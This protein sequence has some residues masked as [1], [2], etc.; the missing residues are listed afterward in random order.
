MPG[1]H[2]HKATILT[3][4]HSPVN[5]LTTPYRSLKY[6]L[7]VKSATTIEK[8]SCHPLNTKHYGERHAHNHTIL[9]FQNKYENRLPCPYAIKFIEDN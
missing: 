8:D 3:D 2:L 4:H 7:I 6:D 1:E 5:L 9:V